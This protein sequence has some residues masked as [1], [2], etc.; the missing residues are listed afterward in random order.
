MPSPERPERDEKPGAARVLNPLYRERLFALIDGA[1]FVRLMSRRI[2][3]LASGRATFE[4]S[5]AEGRRAH[6]RECS[7]RDRA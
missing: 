3:D 2:T 7:R 5:P 6:R 1:P 4:M